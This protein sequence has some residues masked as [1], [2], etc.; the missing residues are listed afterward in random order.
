MSGN[1]TAYQPGIALW[2]NPIYPLLLIF[3]DLGLIGAWIGIIIIF[4]AYLLLLFFGKWISRYFLTFLVVPIF[5]QLN[6]L[7]I[8]FT[9]TSWGLISI[10]AFLIYLINVR[11]YSS[12]RKVTIIFGLM[13][14]AGTALIVPT[15]L[16]YYIPILGILFL[17]DLALK[18]KNAV[19]NILTPFLGVLGSLGVYGLN[20]FLSNKNYRSEIINLYVT[21]LPYN[22]SSVTVNLILDFLSIKGSIRPI[23]DIFDFFGWIIFITFV[24]SLIFSIRFKN[25]HRIVMSLCGAFF[26][27]VTMFGIFEISFFKGRAGIYFLIIF[28]L[29]MA[30]IASYGHKKYLGKWLF[31]FSAGL[32]LSSAYL[33]PVV[34]YR[35][36]DEKIYYKTLELLKDHKITNDAIV[37]TTLPQLNFVSIDFDVRNMDRLFEINPFS[38]QQVIVLL[39]FNM[40]FIDPVLSRQFE[41]QEVHNSDINATL[42]RIRDEKIKKSEEIETRIIK[43]NFTLIFED[44]NYKI[45]S[46]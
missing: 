15:I 10:L 26:G 3:Q 17:I 16:P 23:T 27:F 37:Y 9:S 28:L 36:H 11:K 14:F 46:N 12:Q 31:I 40:D 45:Y 8:G 4:Q 32:A 6:I 1:E 39:D 33:F 42:T 41:Y 29:S 35:Y 38:K 30:I 21:E 18:D 7:F 19:R 5:F 24:L 20:L 22:T 2:L 44:E 25:Q 34:Q 43:H 13:T